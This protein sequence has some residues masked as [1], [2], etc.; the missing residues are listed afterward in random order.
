MFDFLANKLESKENSNLTDSH[1]MIGIG[2]LIVF[3]AMVIVAAVA[4]GVLIQTSGK[5]QQQASATGEE[6]I[7]QVSSGVKI[8]GVKGHSDSNRQIENIILVASLRAG[9]QGINLKNTVLQYTSENE[10]IHLTMEGATIDDRSNV[11]M[12]ENTF[13]VNKIKNPSGTENHMLGGSGDVAEIWISPDSIEDGSG[14]LAGSKVSI[15]LMPPDGFQSYARVVVPVV[16][17]NNK[18]YEL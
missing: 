15:S 14:L 12:N 4:A 6:T 2:T 10:S 5:L 16:L 7:R 3:I 11:T 8:Q 17:G 13:Y 18:T 9:S 1:G